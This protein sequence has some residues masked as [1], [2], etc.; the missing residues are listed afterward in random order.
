MQN[1]DDANFTDTLNDREPASVWAQNHGN[2]L[3]MFLGGLIVLGSAILLYRQSRFVAPRF[4]QSSLIGEAKSTD[5]SS[6]LENHSQITDFLSVTVVGSDQDNGDV[7]VAVY[8]SADAF[9]N[10]TSPRWL[11]KATLREGTAVLQ[12][13]L[14]NL[15]PEF[16]IVAFADQNA[17]GGFDPQLNERIGFSGTLDRSQMEAEDAFEKARITPP[18][19]SFSVTINLL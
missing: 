10:Q 7:M 14:I 2:V 12:L 9:A 18:F 5:E 1:Q 15:G 8:D 16:A 17:N 6:G 19:E 13:P 3:M 4:P 11:D